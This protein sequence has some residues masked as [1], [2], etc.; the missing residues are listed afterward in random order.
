MISR[1]VIPKCQT[2]PS[3]GRVE[4]IT[5]EEGPVPPLTHGAV[6]VQVITYTK[7]QTKFSFEHFLIADLWD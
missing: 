3:S 6:H 5:N 2:V 7:L 4:H 1:H